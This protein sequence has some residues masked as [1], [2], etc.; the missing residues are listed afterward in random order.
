MKKYFVLN[1]KK[2]VKAFSLQ[3]FNDYCDEYDDIRIYDL[4][5]FLDIK[6]NTTIEI[7]K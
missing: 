1:P 2:I 5:T 3:E 4:N 6:I 7:C